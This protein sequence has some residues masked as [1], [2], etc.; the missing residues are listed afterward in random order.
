MTFETSL[1]NP[2][3]IQLIK[4]EI[5]I[6]YVE[7]NARYLLVV[8]GGELDGTKRKPGTRSFPL[9]CETIVVPMR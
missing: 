7:L 8:V 1:L 5:V 6:G 3:R 4:P 2:L 9:H